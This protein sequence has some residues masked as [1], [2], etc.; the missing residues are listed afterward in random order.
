MIFL[1][2]FKGVLEHI[3]DIFRNFS[4]VIVTYFY[5]NEI[6]IMF[7]SCMLIITNLNVRCIKINIFLNGFCK[8]GGEVI[9]LI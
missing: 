3:Y 9:A 1:C 8:H 4:H 7:L 5:V 6:F 2:Y